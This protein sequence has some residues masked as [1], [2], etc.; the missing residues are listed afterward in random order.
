[1]IGDNNFE[2]MMGEL[3]IDSP[4]NNRYKNIYMISFTIDNRIDLVGSTFQDIPIGINSQAYVLTYDVIFKELRKMYPTFVR[5]TDRITI[6]SQERIS[7]ELLI[8]AY[9]AQLN[10]TKNSR[11]DF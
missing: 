6:I 5:E 10:N 3:P 1:M 2:D 7:D 9:S 8:D 4:G 11:E